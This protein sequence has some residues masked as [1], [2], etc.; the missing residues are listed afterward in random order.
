MLPT[1][2]E[3]ARNNPETSLETHGRGFRRAVTVP[4]A[5]LAAE[6]ATAAAIRAYA[7]RRTERPMPPHSG[8]GA[9]E[10][11]DDVRALLPRWTARSAWLRTA[12]ALAGTEAFARLCRD[13]RVGEGISPNTCATAFEVMAE[14][15]DTATGELRASMRALGAR[16]GRGEKTIQRARRVATSL[17]LLLEVYGA[18]ELGKAER[19][20]LVGEHGRHPQRGITNVWQLAFIPP[21]VRERFSTATPGQFIR[22]KCF[23]RLPPKGVSLPISHLWNLVTT[24][25]ADATKTEAAPPPRR[26]G[27]RRPG[28]ALAI[29]LLNSPHQRFITG[30]SPGRLA[31]LLAPYQR[32]GWRGDDLALVL[33]DEARSRGWDTTRPAR[34]PLA[35]LKALLERIETIADPTTAWAPVPCEHCHHSPGRIRDLPLRTVSICTPCWIVLSRSPETRCSNP[36]CDRGYITT[37]PTVDVAQATITRCRECCA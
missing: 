36:D 14:L 8:I 9:G 5:V 22:I 32:G 7:L 35:A 12:R 31:G 34:A 30:T 11:P 27:G 2:A 3:L 28:S 21:R 16:L 10:I 25:A 24:V 29:E 20:V 18:R 17:G 33:L 4:G 26:Q 37:T 15:A 1:I 13:K 23:G 6:P 19:D